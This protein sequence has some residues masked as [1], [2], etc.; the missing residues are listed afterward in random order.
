MP[1]GE[2]KHSGSTII[3]APAFEA[4]STRDLAWERFLPLSGPSSA[5]ASRS[6][7]VQERHTSGKLNQG[8]FDRLHQ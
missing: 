7:R 8:Q 1:Y 4:S 6:F 3:F 2:L 5:S